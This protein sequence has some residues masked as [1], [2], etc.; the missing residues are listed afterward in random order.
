MVA[1]YSLFISLVALSTAV[2]AL[3]RPSLPIYNSKNVDQV[4]KAAL[5]S[6]SGAGSVESF[7]V[8]TG[9]DFY[10]PGQAA[11]PSSD[12]T[13]APAATSA[14]PPSI[15]QD[16]DDVISTLTVG[17]TTPGATPTFPSFP[18]ITASASVNSS[19]ELFASL[20]SLVARGELDPRALDASTRSKLSK[21]DGLNLISIYMSL[22]S[23]RDAT[24]VTA[25][26]W[27]P[28]Q[29]ARQSL[30]ASYQS[31]LA[32]SSASKSSSRAA[33]SSS[34]AAAAAASSS[35]KSAAAAATRTTTTTARTIGADGASRTTTT[36]TKT[37]TTAKTTTTTRSASTTTTRTTTTSRT[38]TTTRA[39]T[40]TTRTTTSATATST[41]SGL[42]DGVTFWKEKTYFY[43]LASFITDVVDKS[44]FSWGKTNVDVVT[45]GPPAQNWT[46]GI[47]TDTRPALQVKYPAGSR[48]PGGSI[49]GGVG[50]YSSKIDITQAS[51]V[52][53]SY[54]VFFPT[55]FNFVKGGKLPGL[56]GGAKACS[57]GSAAESCFSTRLMFRQNGMGELYLYAP[58]EKQVSALCSLGPLSYC[59]SVYGMSIGR[60]SW[61]FKTGEWTDIRQ[62]IWLNTPGVADGGFNIWVNG[63]LV[64]HS[65]QVYYRNSAV[66][67]VGI[68][69]QNSTSIELI[70]Y[71]SIP[72]NV[73]IPNGGFVNYPSNSTSGGGSNNGGGGVFSPS[74]V[75]KIVQ[76]TA[77]TSSASATGTDAYDPGYPTSWAP[78]AEA[79]RARRERKWV[80]LDKAALPAAT[81]APELEKRATVASVPG[82]MGAMVQTFFGGSSN[83]YNSPVDQ[84]TY[85]RGLALEIN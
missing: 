75:T 35:S 49:Q 59:N 45:E 43:S 62:D 52:S 27:L 78:D 17:R 22:V 73:V 77:T 36:T 6:S 61:T 13:A 34:K 58:R 26:P 56:Y 3:P 21:R 9:S 30:Q 38:T 53:F 5:P 81:T 84:Y 51:N 60:G 64:L 46:N 66:G 15:V 50:F 74:F 85:F 48:N 23:S 54:S 16:G 4:I 18:T 70:D 57:G 7:W 65:D 71:D 19:A 67:N 41:G 79:R 14:Y 42:T 83:D 63:E 1:A 33:A 37:S 80:V 72:D 28:A 31:R 76:P 24:G 55:G 47:V 2:S 25:S 8:A 29:I 11:A 39:S 40:T 10:L 82:F 20:S 12:E 69:G 44:V 32:A 68:P